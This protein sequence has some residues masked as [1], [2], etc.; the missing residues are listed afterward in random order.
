MVAGLCHI[1]L[2]ANEINK[3]NGFYSLI[4]SGSS[5]ICL[6]DEEYLVDERAVKKLEDEDIDFNKVERDV[7]N[8]EGENQENATETQI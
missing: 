4:T 2:N 8:S 5:V 6:D 3:D 1:K 7:E